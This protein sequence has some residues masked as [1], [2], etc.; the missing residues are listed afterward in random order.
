MMAQAATFPAVAPALPA[1]TPESDRPAARVRG[2]ELWAGPIDPLILR[3]QRGDRMAFR[4]LFRQHRSEVARVVFRVV[5]PSSEID[6]VVQ[7]VF[8]QVHRSIQ[9]FRGQS[10]FSTWLHRVGVNVALQFLRKKRASL[11]AATTADLPEAA[12]PEGRSDP[13]HRTLSGE[14]LAAV[15]RV[16]ATLS[17]KKRVVFVLHDLEGVAAGDIGKMLGIPV[18][19]VRTRL[20]YA[21]K[22]FFA[23]ISS[24]PAFE[25]KEGTEP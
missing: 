15:Y 12:E 10:K 13:L 5:G 24:E 18:L 23:R 4:E 2:E 16:L 20:F 7:E 21:R 6:D 1:L 17:E 11:P 8:F 25:E 22:E 14:R 19:T 9:A 3:C